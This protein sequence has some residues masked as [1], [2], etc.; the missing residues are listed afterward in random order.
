MSKFLDKITCEV[1][2]GR[3]L[4]REPIGSKWVE[5]GV[6]IE[7][8]FCDNHLLTRYKIGVEFMNSFYAKDYAEVEHL[9]IQFIE[10]VRIA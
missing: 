4:L 5:P 3:K 6:N 9:K 10:A 1:L 2:G 7:A 8:E